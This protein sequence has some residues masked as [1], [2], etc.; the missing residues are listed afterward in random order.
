MIQATTCRMTPT[1]IAACQTRQAGA[2][3]AVRDGLSRT[4]EVPGRAAEADDQARA[5]DDRQPAWP[6][7]PAAGRRGPA[8]RRRAP[9]SRETR[10]PARCRSAAI[11]RWSDSRCDWRAYCSAQAAC[12]REAE[13]VV[14][15]PRPADEDEAGRESTATTTARSGHGRSP[16]PI[17]LGQIKRIEPDD[18]HRQDR[19]PAIEQQQ[20][21]RVELAAG[22]GSAGTAAAR[23][24]P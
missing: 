19:H 6:C 15:G 8:A 1:T 13:Q 22:R 12:P 5:G 20:V 7:L 23:R 9:P 3:T 17:A 14:L 11:A 16:Q 18:Q 21:G 4:T 10:R 2:R 24:P